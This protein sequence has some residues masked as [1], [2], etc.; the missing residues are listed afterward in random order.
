MGFFGL[1][2]ALSCVA[3]AVCTSAVGVGRSVPRTPEVLVRSESHQM[4]LSQ[5]PIGFPDGSGWVLDTETGNATALKVGGETFH[6]A[7]FAGWVDA[8]GERQVAGWWVR[9]EGSEGSR[10]LTGSGLGR[11]SYPSG[12]VL[13]RI[14][15]VPVPAH[16]PC[17]YPGPDPR[18]LFATSAGALVQYSFDTAGTDGSCA[19]SRLRPIRWLKPPEILR[20]PFVEYLVWLAH[21]GL[22]GRI[23]ASIRSEFPNSSSIARAPSRLWWLR[24]SRDG[25]SVQDAEPADDGTWR[26]DRE[27]GASL[28]ALS[29]QPDGSALVAFLHIVSSGHANGLCI[30]PLEIDGARGTATIRLARARKL[31]DEIC[32]VPPAFSPDGKSLY[33]VRRERGRAVAVRR[34]AIA[35]HPWDESFRDGGRHGDTDAG[36]VLDHVPSEIAFPKREKSPG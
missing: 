36:L 6:T 28:P 20:H 25:L 32:E 10:V 15:E 30:A 22:R 16:P 18:I 4:F 35:A 23:L 31:D 21:P 26:A 19:S 13:D 11:V 17:W 2:R 24:L 5:F 3:L 1:R 29:M 9:F 27:Q 12:R 7:S 34:Y 14:E 8:S 33:A